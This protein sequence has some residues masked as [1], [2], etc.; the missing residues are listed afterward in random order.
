MSR[1]TARATGPTFPDMMAWRAVDTV[2]SVERCPCCGRPTR[3][4]Q[5]LTL[6]QRR[7]FDWIAAYE[8]THGAFPAKHEIC[9]G[10]GFRSL[11]TA[12]EHIDNL[13]RKGWLVRIGSLGAARAYATVGKG[14][15][16]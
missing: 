3:R 1:L 16:R 15:P 4:R 8:R 11:A 9:T 6:H 13:E 12:W 5:P 10:L 14:V 2:A 7:I